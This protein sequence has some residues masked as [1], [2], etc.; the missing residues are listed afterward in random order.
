M[1]DDSSITRRNAMAAMSTTLAAF[2]AAAV[3]GLS[4]LFVTAPLRAITRRRDADLGAP[5]DFGSTFRAVDLH[6]PVN[7]GWHSHEDSARVYARLDESG[8]PL[9]LSA[10]CTHLG[11]TVQWD[12]GTG[13]FRCPCHGGRFAPDGAVLGGPPPRPLRRLRANVRDGRVTAELG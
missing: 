11:C 1:N 10:T 6:M 5:T 9:V 7:D 13:E 4:T 12:A 8:Q 2:W 3:A